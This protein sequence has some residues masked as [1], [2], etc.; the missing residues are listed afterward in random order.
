MKVADAVGFSHSRGIIHR[1]LKPENV[2]LGDFGEVL[3]MDWG[4]AVPTDSRLIGGLRPSTSMGG[5]PA[6]MAP[7]MATGPFERIG[8]HSDVYLLGAILFEVVTGKPPHTGKDVMKC[9][10]AAAKNQIQ[11]VEHPSE[12]VDIAMK[13]MSTDPKDRHG[14][15]IEFQDA[16]RQYL[17]HSESILL[18]D[19]AEQ[20]LATA[21]RT[22]DYQDYSRAL[23]GFQQAIEL[24]DGNEP[25]KEGLSLTQV[26][27]ATSARDKGD[28]DLG[29]SLLDAE[30]PEQVELLSE[31]REAKREVEA[32]QHRLKA[33][34]RALMALAA[35]VFIVVLG[36]LGLVLKAK[37]ETERQKV[38]A[39]KNEK[40][41]VKQKGIAEKNLVLAKKNEAEAIEERERAEAAALAEKKAK[42][43]A[44]AAALAEKKAKEEAVL[45]RE[46]AEA[47]ALAEKK[48]KEEA[49]AAALAEM[50][51]KVAAEKAALAE[52]KA[53]DEA[54][55]ARKKAEAA[56]LAEKKAKEAAE[57]AALAEKKAKD[58]AVVERKK[59]EAAALAEKKA[60][61]EAEAAALAEKKAK[62][63][64]VLERKKAEA[65]A[66]AEK[67]AK[68]K[69]EIEEQKARLAEAEAKRQAYTALIS[70]A[71][72]KIE[73]NAFDSAREDLKKCD[74]IYR[75]WE[76]GRLWH[77]C[78][79]SVAE[80]DAQA[81]IA[82]IDF[83]PIEKDK[84][85]A[86]GSLD[87]KVRIW[88]LESGMSDSTLVRTLDTG[89]DEVYALAFAPDGKQIAVGTGSADGYLQIW[90][91]D[92]GEPVAKIA[93]GRRDGMLSKVAHTQDVVSVQFDAA[94]D[95]LLTSSYDA[96]AKVWDVTDRAHPKVRSTLRGHTWWVWSASFSPDR[97]KILTVS[98]D[99]NAIVWTAQTGRW[100]HDANIKASPKFRGHTGPIF[101]GGFTPDGETVATAGYGQRVLLWKPSEL[102][103][104]DHEAAVASFDSNRPFRSTDSTKA[105]VLDGHTGPVRSLT[106]S[107]DGALL[108]T[109]GED[110][111]IRVW[112]IQQDVAPVVLR[113][114]GKAV[115]GCDISPK[116]Q[117]IVSGSLDGTARLWDLTRYEEQR[118]LRGDVLEGHGDAVLSAFFTSAAAYAEEQGRRIVTASRD[119][120]AKTWNLDDKQVEKTFTEGHTLREGHLFR[121]AQAEFFADDKYLATS[122]VD[123]TVRIWDVSRGTQIDLLEDTGRN[124]ALAVSGDG[125]LIITGSDSEGE[126]DNGFYAQ[127]WQ[128]KKGE[129][130]K[131]LFKLGNH[132]K[133]VTQVA[134]SP[135]KRFIATGDANGQCNLWDAQTGALTRGLSWHVNGITALDFLPDSSRLLTADGEGNVVQW[136]L[137]SYQPLKPLIVQLG[138]GV[139]SMDTAELPESGK[140]AVVLSTDDGRVEL[141]DVDRGSR[142]KLRSL[143]AQY[144]FGTPDDAR[145]SPDGSRVMVV[146]APLADAAE[147]GTEGEANVQAAG[148]HMFDSESGEEIEFKVAGQTQGPFL[149]LGSGS[150]VSSATFNSDGTRVATVGGNRA[151]M[152]KTDPGVDQAER[153]V[154]RFRPHGPIA[155]ARFSPDAESKYIVTGSW[156]TTI[157]IWDTTNQQNQLTL[158][159]L[160]TRA[161]NSVRLFQD[162]ESM[163]ALSASDDGTA[164]LWPFDP[165]SVGSENAS[166]QAL[167]VFAHESG[168]TDA[169]FIASRNQVV[170][171]SLDGGVRVWDRP[172]LDGAETPV[173]VRKPAQELRAAEDR[174]AGLLCVAASY[175]GRWIVAGGE[176]DAKLWDLDAEEVEPFDTLT[177]HTAPV[178]SVEFS[179]KDD[180]SRRLLTGS[181]DFTAKVW[182]SSK[183]WEEPPKLE[184]N[185]LELDAAA[186]EVNEIMTLKGHSRAVTSVTFSP[187]G[188]YCLTASHDGTAIVWLTS[189]W[190]VNN[191]RPDAA[192]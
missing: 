58:E 96:T 107:N 113:G 16:I 30:K 59:A 155:T 73:E 41:A 12:L 182:D 132:L 166:V 48:A 121:A 156:D 154:M 85:F 66:L 103:E 157:K 26:A 64:A 13:A 35:T 79:Q 24:W 97:K 105:K 173:V 106:F 108:L 158:K 135:D 188:K 92:S 69:A 22:D 31:I 65:A 9:L 10:F 14:S 142:G 52:K 168:V 38:L 57:K 114:H 43:E 192:E 169:I 137:K 3:V 63:E 36:A 148:V 89:R 104:F 162:K 122:A 178:T 62:E 115:Q 161:V 163:F 54:I 171:T 74:P 167:V 98:D 67:K 32:R 11:K 44:E 147:V 128:W 145:F 112:N 39:E 126:S 17:S 70:A 191:E 90:D 124:A 80:M 140:R 7:E 119:G 190:Q 15:V 49:E 53:K 46:R 189:D 99:G 185:E 2:M 55:T 68:E 60:K 93:S 76:W 180:R 21:S 33:T 143:A 109:A 95:L 130:A 78:N 176:E 47:A 175:D 51:A 149:F 75:N 8:I 139:T 71:A 133:T 6:Y 187:D 174:S 159:G 150:S 4:L 94:G 127:A 146:A 186:R 18:S 151:Q 23:F 87:G 100:E 61:E 84:Q 37:A 111:T 19:H 29:A 141:Y 170:T 91:V 179:G 83:S 81:E 160:H 86:T 88:R 129:K 172:G 34:K 102:K 50:K 184:G 125:S 118:V 136:D 116:S 40:E 153:E 120:T 1:D 131:L 20:D 164:K 82:A 77:L 56:A 27:Y 134:V 152:W 181:K 144:R 101:A 165:E 72:G 138:D 28:F 45:E 110:N 25:A 117:W 123:N 5:T 177:G 183:L 42:E